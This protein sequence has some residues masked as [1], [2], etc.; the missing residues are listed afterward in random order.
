M[1]ER[2]T[3]KADCVQTEWSREGYDCIRHNVPLQ[4][5]SRIHVQWRVNATKLTFNEMWYRLRLYYVCILFSFLF[6][7]FKFFK[8]ISPPHILI[9]LTV[10]GFLIPPISLPLTQPQSNYH[11]LNVSSA[12]TCINLRLHWPRLY[13]DSQKLTVKAIPLSSR[14]LIYFLNDSYQ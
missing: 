3:W 13:I 6:F 12:P 5:R 10:K 1:M 7:F 11:Q 2:L 9:L 4:Q 14:R 8:L